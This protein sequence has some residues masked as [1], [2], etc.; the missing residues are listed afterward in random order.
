[1][2]PVSSEDSGQSNSSYDDLGSRLDTFRDQV[3]L[4]LPQ[5]YTEI[6]KQEHVEHDNEPKSP[7]NYFMCDIQNLTNYD[8]KSSIQMNISEQIVTAN[9][10]T[11]HKKVFI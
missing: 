10:E 9:T 5:I 8:T 11:D 1:M 3:M 2:N 6:I 4:E 7:N